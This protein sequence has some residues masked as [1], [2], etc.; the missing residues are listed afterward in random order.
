MFEKYLGGDFIRV[1]L[2]DAAHYHPFPKASEREVWSRINF[3]TA[4]I[5]AG[6][7]AKEGY[8]MLKA[9]DFMAFTRTGNR[10]IYEGPYR[11]CIWY[12]LSLW[13]KRAISWTFL[14]HRVD[15]FLSAGWNLVPRMYQFGVSVGLPIFY[16]FFRN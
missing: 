9:S 4:V 10:K 5:A 2:K 14:V 1:S 15:Y 7:G 6:E 12:I 16:L 8:P 13:T 11:N 3:R